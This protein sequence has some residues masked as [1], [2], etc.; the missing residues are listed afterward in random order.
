MNKQELVT[1]IAEK[2][3]ITKK[4][5]EESLTAF[6]STIEEAMIAGEKV[7]LIGFGSF[8]PRERKERDGRNLKTGES[9]K[10]PASKTAVFKVGKGL[11]DALNK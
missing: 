3:G 6:T 1:K 5:A 2:A 11:K 9:L 10:I 8:E 7:Q 4:Q